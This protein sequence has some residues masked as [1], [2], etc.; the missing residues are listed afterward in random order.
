[1]KISDKSFLKSLRSFKGLPHR[2]EIFL[3]NK[4]KVFI[5]DSKAT[6]FEASKFALQNNKNIFWIVGGT[7][8]LGDKFK[9]AKLKKNIF[10]SY[11]IGKYMVNFKNQ[12]K[13]KV[14]FQLCGTLENAVNAVFKSIQKIKN[15][16]LT[17]LFS[18]AGSSYDQFK[19][20]EERG[21]KF[22]KLIKSYA[23]KYA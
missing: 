12:L 11:V 1:M 16:K 9:L 19:N 20:F 18:P 7:P 3:K 10:K 6:T 8:K 21:T 23:K 15:E 13:G 5:N 17:I 2:H 4:N 22:K 14:D